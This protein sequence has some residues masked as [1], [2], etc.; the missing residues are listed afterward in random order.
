[1]IKEGL[2]KEWELRMNKK[3]NNFLNAIIIIAENENTA[4]SNA[5]K[6]IAIE[7]SN[8]LNKEDKN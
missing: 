6:E 2:E 7:I 8:I 5:I 3:I 1:M 4:E